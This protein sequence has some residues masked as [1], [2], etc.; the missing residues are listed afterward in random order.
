MLNLLIRR[1]LCPGLEGAGRKRTRQIAQANSTVKPTICS[2]SL[3]ASTTSEILGRTRERVNEKHGASKYAA[4]LSNA[5][6]GISTGAGCPFRL[7]TLICPAPASGS[8]PKSRN[9]GESAL[10]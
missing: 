1:R 9:P 5:G 3:L 8:V 6:L 4:S 10:D 2:V 7:K